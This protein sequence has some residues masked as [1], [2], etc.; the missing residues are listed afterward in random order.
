[1]RFILLL[2]LLCLNFSAFS[3]IFVV[4]S[5]ADSGPGSLREALQKAAANGVGQKDY[6]H[7]NLPGSTDAQRTIILSAELPRVTSNLIIDA[8]TQPGRFLGVSSSKIIIKPDRSTYQ[9]SLLSTAAFF[10]AEAHDVEIYGFYFTGFFTSEISMVISLMHNL[11]V[12][13]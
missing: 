4:T 9:A 3:E 13:S 6:I 11:V 12:C 10:I 5:N 2:I 8:T 7:F 1:M